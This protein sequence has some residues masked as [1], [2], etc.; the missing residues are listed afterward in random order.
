MVDAHLSGMRFSDTRRT[1]VVGR[2]EAG[3]TVPEIASTTGHD[4]DECQRTSI[5]LCRGRTYPRSRDL[6]IE[7]EDALET[8]ET[9]RGGLHLSNDIKD[10][11][12]P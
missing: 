1:A 2:A 5:P 11:V 10:M 4:I 8:L 12:R 7:V 9:S 6:D 3:C